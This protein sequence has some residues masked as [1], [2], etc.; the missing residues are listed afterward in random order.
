MAKSIKHNGSEDSYL[1]EQFEAPAGKRSHVNV[2]FLCLFVLCFQGML[3]CAE[4]LSKAVFS[5]GSYLFTV[6]LSLL[7]S[8]VCYV[9]DVPK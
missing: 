2:L 1:L 7:G 3:Y 8:S 9:L 6:V 5:L 4:S